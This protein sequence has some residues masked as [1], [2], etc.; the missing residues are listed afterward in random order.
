MFFVHTKLILSTQVEQWVEFWRNT[1]ICYKL[2][3]E[4]EAKEFE[5]LIMRQ[6]PALQAEVIGWFVYGGSALNKGCIFSIV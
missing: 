2:L 6:D 1:K 3:R 4:E 5:T